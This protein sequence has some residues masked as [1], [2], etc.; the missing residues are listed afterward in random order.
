MPATT[1]DL[2][3]LYRSMVLIREAEE[4][5]LRLFSRTGCP[6]SSTPT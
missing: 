4:T 2:K 6:A 5:L 3:Y 1:T